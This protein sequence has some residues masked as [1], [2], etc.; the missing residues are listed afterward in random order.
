M[1]LQVK[2]HFGAFAEVVKYWTMMIRGYKGMGH[3]LCIDYVEE[4]KYKIF[5]SW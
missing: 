4:C 1:Q 5:V 3:V 2:G